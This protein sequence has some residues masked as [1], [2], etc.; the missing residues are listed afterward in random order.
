[1]KNKFK[2]KIV[3]VAGCAIILLWPANNA[4]AGWANDIFDECP[5]DQCGAPPSGGIGGGGAAAVLL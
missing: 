3:L 1:M 4:F 2:K 5:D